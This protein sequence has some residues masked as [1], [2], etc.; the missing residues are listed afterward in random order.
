MGRGEKEV[1]G[2]DEKEVGGDDKQSMA[3][4][5]GTNLMEVNL[6]T[7]KNTG[8]RRQW[9]PGQ[10]KNSQDITKQGY[11]RKRRK[12]KQQNTETTGKYVKYKTQGSEVKDKGRSQVTKLAYINI[13]GKMWTERNTIIE[14]IRNSNWDIVCFTE[15]HKRKD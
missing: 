2:G 5:T 10:E 13:Q 8:I 15:T 11:R 14:Q 4:S 1:N 3:W 9:Q 6:K 7:R 12:K